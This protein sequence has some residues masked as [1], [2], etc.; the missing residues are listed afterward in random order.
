MERLFKVL[1]EDHRPANGGTGEW[2]LPTDDDRPGKWMP[3]IQ[4]NLIPCQNGYHLCREKDL[5]EWLGPN[6]YLAECRGDRIDE[7]N[8][9]IVREARL[10][11]HL[12]TWD[13]CSAR[14]FAAECARRVL[15]IYEKDYPSDDR[16][17]KAI[18]V[19]E[20]FAVGDIDDA[21]VAAAVDAAVDAAGAAARA[22]AVDAARAAARAAEQEWQTKTLMD[23]L[24]SGGE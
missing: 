12:W 21:A 4:G 13:D 1:N 3:P 16:P 17:R 19:A 11:K 20:A 22:A 23:L 10:T 9:I 6:I 24:F 2:N 18:E 15:P 7:S 8:K 5:I 14:L